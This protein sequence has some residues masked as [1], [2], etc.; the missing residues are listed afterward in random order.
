MPKE[1]LNIKKPCYNKDYSLNGLYFEM[2]KYTYK[3]I[4][5]KRGQSGKVY[6]CIDTL[7]NTKTKQKKT[8]TRKELIEVLKKYKAKLKNDEIDKLD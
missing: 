5:T 8:Y 1:K 6:S 3:I 2:G 4:E 7:Q